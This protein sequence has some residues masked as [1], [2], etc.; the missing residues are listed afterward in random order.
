MASGRPTIV[1]N[2]KIAGIIALAVVVALVGL[3]VAAGRNT[4]PKTPA[5]LPVLGAGGASTMAAAPTSDMRLMRPV[6]YEAS[7]DLSALDSEAGAYV[8]GSRTTPDRTHDLMQALGLGAKL[9]QTDAAWSVVDGEARLDIQRVGG[10]PW[11]YSRA[12]GAVSSSG[13]VVCGSPCPPDAQCLVA[14]CPTEE[15]QRPADLPTKAAAEAIARAL[16]DKVGVDLTQARV[17]VEDGF[18]VWNVSADPEIDGHPVVG[19]TTSIAIGPKSAVIYAN[20]WL[21]TVD[22]GD[23][24]PLIGTSAGLKQLNENQVLPMGGPRPMIAQVRPECD[25]AA[26]CID[27]PPSEPTVVQITGVRLGLELFSSYEPGQPAY[28][29]PAYLFRTQDDGD[30]LPVIAVDEQYLAPAPT[31]KAPGGGSGGGTDGVPPPSA[32]EPGRPTQTKPAP[33]AT[34]TP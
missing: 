5:T 7:G 18:S 20:G 11:S 19:M 34:S 29:V 26:D 9:T 17:K 32:V 1:K 25:P 8:V 4:E 13:S 24:Y 12:D 31:P 10:L 3:A 15:P 27:P 14:D 16:L 28:L 21:G 2:R 23:R 6:R 22:A 33:P 30:E